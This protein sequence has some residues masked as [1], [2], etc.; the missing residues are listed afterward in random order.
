MYIRMFGLAE[1]LKIGFEM[2]RKIKHS[3]G[4]IGFIVIAPKLYRV[5]LA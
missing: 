5:G 2:E 1:F 4:A 3:A